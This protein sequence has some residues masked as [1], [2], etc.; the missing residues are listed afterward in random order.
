MNYTLINDDCLK[1]LRRSPRAP[2]VDCIFADP[3]DNTGAKYGELCQDKLAEDKYLNMLR[4]WLTEFIQS[5]KT[6]W[7]SYNSKWTFEIGR[8]V[9]YLI[10]LSDGK[11]EAKSCVQVFTF[12]QHN[13]HDLGNNHRPLLRLRWPDAP[14]FPDAV[15]ITSWRQL[16]GDKRANPNGRVPGDVF[17]FPRVTGN[18]KQRRNW[19]PNQLHEGLIERCIKLS[20]PEGGAVLD[21]FAGTGTTLRVC[22]RINRNCTLI[23]IN[24]SFCE[25]ISREHGIDFIQKHWHGKNGKPRPE[26]CQYC[27]G[28]LIE[29]SNR[30]VVCENGCGRL[31]PSVSFLGK[32]S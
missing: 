27:G 5:A 29:T 6:V 16:N 24:K 9:C 3:P 14:I 7:L 22:K 19:C 2:E 25:E 23:E 4:L 15:R 30:W 11:L 21:P 13:K 17:D 31:I 32:E 18:S 20:T 28:K 1:V 12:G 26:C 8:I 10:G